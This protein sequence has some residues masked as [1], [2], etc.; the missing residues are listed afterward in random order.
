M[1]ESLIFFD[2]DG[3]N[4]N[5][6]YNT[7]S[8]KYEGRL[9][10]HENSDDTFR[11]I[12]LN[13]FERIEPFDFQLNDGE[14]DQLFLN[15]FQLFNEFG[16]DYQGTQFKKQSVDNITVTNEDPDF[17][18][19]W[20]YGENFE[21]KFPK[22]TE[23][24]F[25]DLITEFN[26]NQTYTV[27]GTKK[28]AIMV[29]SNM[30][31]DTYK[32]TYSGLPI[33]SFDDITVDGINAIQ[34]RKYVDQNVE[35]NL[36]SWSEPFFY[37]KV[38]NGQKLSIVNSENND[39]VK[40]VKDQ[41]LDNTNW[42][43]FADG[44]NLGASQ[45]F[46]VE[47][48]LLTDLPRV[49]NGSLLI[50]GTSNTLTFP[51]N[52]PSLLRPGAEFKIASSQLNQ[53]FYVVDDIE[54]FD[55][56]PGK[57]YATGSQVI[58]EGEIYENI[59]EYTQTTSTIEDSTNLSGSSPYTLDI[60]VEITPE[61]TD[62]WQVSNYIPVVQNLTTENILSSKIYLTD[63]VLYF[64][65]PF[66]TN[67]KITLAESV[68]QYSEDLD[69]FDIS[70]SYDNNSNIVT[71]DLKYSSKYAEVKF[72]SGNLNND[73]TQSQFDYE[74]VIEVEENLIPESNKNLS[75]RDSWNI[76]IDDL[77]EFGM[78]VTING[79][80]Y[81]VD[82]VFIFS[83]I[84]IDLEKTV[85]KTL[86]SWIK[87]HS[88][89]LLKLG[90]ITEN[91]YTG[92]L[93][94]PYVN[95]LNLR[96]VYPNVPL[97]FNVRV[98]TT[99]NYVIEH[100]NIIIYD[101]GGVL[102]IRINGVSLIEN[103]DTDVSTTLSNWV[104][105]HSEFLF[106][107]DIVVSSNNQVLIFDTLQQ[108]TLLDIDIRLGKSFK[109]GEKDFKIINK[110]SGNEGNIITA[111]E[112]IHNTTDV[113]FEDNNF[114]TGQILSINNSFFTLNNREYN[115]LFLDPDKIILSYEG[116][117]WGNTQSDILSGFLGYAFDDGFGYDPNAPNTPNP[118]SPTFS[119]NIV[120]N[121]DG[122]VD[123]DY[124]QPT[125]NIFTL[126]DD[127]KVIDS[128]TMD[129]VDTLLGSTASIKSEI[130]PVN[131]LLYSLTENVVYYIDP[132]L[133]EIVGFINLPAT[134]YDI[135]INDNNG[136]IYISYSDSNI[137][138]IYDLDNIQ[139]VQS[140]LNMN[141]NSNTLEFNP[142][143]DNMYISEPLNNQLTEVNGSGHN[144]TNTYVITGISEEI[145]YNPFNNEI[146]GFDNTSLYSISNGNISNITSVPS[147]TNS[148]FTF[149]PIN[150][151][152]IV[153]TTDGTIYEI[154][155]LNNVTDSIN[156]GF[157][158]ELLFNN[159]D[160]NIY[161]ASNNSSDLLV[162]STVTHDVFINVS[163]NG[164]MTKM[165]YNQNRQSIVGIIPST[166]EIIEFIV[167]TLSSPTL[168]S[169]S[170][171]FSNAYYKSS[172]DPCD[173]I[174]INDN[175]YGSLKEDYCEDD[176][177]LLIKVREY[178]RRPRANFET[179]DD[180]QVKYKWHWKDDQTPDI[181]LYDITGDQ[182]ESSG[183]YAYSGDTPLTDIRL[184][185]S[186][187]RDITK[188]EDQ[189]AQQTIFDEI[190]YTLDYVD[191]S[192][193]FNFVP[194]PL[195]THIGFNSKQE[196]VKNSTLLL[197]RIE[198]IEFNILTN[199]TNDNEI[200]FK[201]LND[202]QGNSW[203]EIKLNSMS[204]YIFLN[205]NLKVGQILQIFV[206]DNTNDN[207][208]YISK[209][210]GIKLKI[211]NVFVRTIVVD[212]IDTPIYDETTIIE[213]YPKQGENTYLSTRFK[214][215]D[216]IIANFNI[217][218]QTE[219][220][221]I[222]YKIELNN[223]GKNIKPEDIYIFKDYDISEQGIDWT[224]LNK[225]RKEMLLVRPD[226]FDYIG[227]Y[228]AIINAIN[229]FG[230]NDL[231]LHEY[232]RNTKRN[233]ENFNKLI[234]TEIPDI[235]NP[236]LPGWKDDE[237]LLNVLP[238]AEYEATNL[239]NLSYRITDKQGNFVLNYSLDEVIIKLM[240]LKK[241][242]GKN[243][244]P[245]SHRILDITGNAD[246]VGPTTIYHDNYDV[247][248]IKSTNSMTPI[249]F[250]VNEAYILPVNSGSTVYNVVIDFNTQTDIETPDYFNVKIRTY[251]ILKDWKPFK[252]YSIGDEIRYLGKHYESIEND[253]ITNNPREFQDTSRWRGDNQYVFG[254]EVEYNR[255]IYQYQSSGVT[256]SA[257]QSSQPP[258]N[259][260]DWFRIS[261]WRELD[262]DPVQTISEYRDG[263]DTNPYNFTIDTNIDPYVIIE[264]TSDN[265]YGQNY[266][267]RKSVEVRLDAD[268][269]ELIID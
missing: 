188:T 124:I 217:F 183:S 11:T 236:S 4:V 211:R 227:S 79:L 99:A 245:I 268:S 149:D 262:L 202:N 55:R 118:I 105:T 71:T 164:T 166:N 231:E 34:I 157:Y 210:Y 168:R 200:S 184:N 137:I 48:T 39:G 19:K 103:F 56:T 106:S 114:S 176:K 151:K 246:V 73:I 3:N 116:P 85:D 218:G 53:N 234:K 59:Q 172:S 40:T 198:D 150:D 104:N 81:Y 51:N 195:Q 115:V 128:S 38:F 254:Q 196:G 138:S 10:F 194:K 230:Y 171:A 146:Y 154:D 91:L 61:D 97:D 121:S 148:W 25:N 110:K 2:K 126:G 122:L 8:E 131:E 107:I 123:I 15:K 252:R 159:F 201:V 88:N 145:Y 13:T 32:S 68:E 190:L 147:S 244:I 251:Q 31:N 203:G 214:V 54:L 41:L 144:V 155:G 174:P 46:I 191:S 67:T 12:T 180:V 80:E 240:G 226:I 63:N 113:N 6:N 72:Y 22:G 7:D 223:T 82:T 165:A 102:N 204:Q 220:E 45:S 193:N 241:W 261:N 33:S 237:N 242:L 92:Y 37:D 58:W 57:V 161:I 100:S 96:T 257:T 28:G 141:N 112:I 265:G 229:Y 132:V 160:G 233:S 143:E 266:T 47:L 213:N 120:G 75:V 136:D 1:N 258:F 24:K 235:F 90:I 224:F 27:V 175:F 127:I 64:E 94:S 209:N 43:Y 216:K 238:N 135:D 42:K 35:P 247:E 185:R 16:I 239:F 158:G 18:T 21:S 206:T 23:I 50:D 119:A 117:F 89:K 78:Y 255:D 142:F 192:S 253:N 182:L 49:Y 243:V 77:D 260:S 74:R 62:Y 9:F 162:Y 269:S 140:P 52:V 178:I 101:I 139:V 65:T 156:I 111:N 129:I 177:L 93:S 98:G 29:V 130:N 167:N 153:S 26:T 197:S 66:D 170:S 228:K 219:I 5:L 256:F 248:F 44:D 222:R 221:D 207:N 86:R 186:P 267:V 109:P 208:Q 264:V 173:G 215:V 20:I 189:T 212:F 232:F 133:E 163:L 84:N 76:L 70:Y 250:N 205:R 108:N 152:M 199:S 95:T 83:G 187:N 125:E 87:Q 69:F 179:D 181:F 14:T 30:D 17:Y 36:S 249:N 60:G 169:F 263:G 225:K 259:N 134:A